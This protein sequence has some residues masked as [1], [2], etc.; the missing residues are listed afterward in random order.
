MNLQTSLTFRNK[1]L[2]I[3]QT[4]PYNSLSMDTVNIIK[5]ITLDPISPPNIVGSFKYIIHEYP[6]D[7]DL[8]ESYS[9]CCNIEQAIN[10]IS[11][12][13]SKIFNNINNNKNIYLGDFKAGFDDRYFINIGSIKKN[14]L[15]DYNPEQIRKSI[16]TLYE[17]KLLEEK[18]YNIWIS[19]VI[20]RPSLYEYMDLEH[21]IRSKYIIRWTLSELL[22]GYKILPLNVKL[23]F[24]DALTHKSIIKIDLWAYLNKRFVEITNWYSLTFKDDNG[25][26]TYLS[27]KPEKYEESLTKDLQYYN[28]PDIH[29][30]MKFAKRLWSYGVLKKNYELLASLYPLFSSGAAKMYQIMG[31]IETISKIIKHIKKPYYKAIH[32]NFEDWKLRLGTIMHNILPINIAHDIYNKINELLVTKNK[33]VM[34][35][36]LED[37]SDKLNKHINDYVLVYFK[38][39]KIHLE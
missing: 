31:E 29:K 32:D 8:F 16:V 28:N 20:N 35:I 24:K 36:I 4:R 10:D 14:K 1:D 39:N 19:K 12:K 37:I 6:A 11:K 38:Q 21:I 26:V 22:L 5:M 27:T 30:Y 17:N 23:S 18:E 2:H 34:S 7:I 9:S 13:F 3:L 15:I 33:E 25:N